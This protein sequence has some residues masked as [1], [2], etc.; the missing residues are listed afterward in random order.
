MAAR[1]VE[2]PE[3]IIVEENLDPAATRAF[4][5]NAFGDGPILP[6]RHRDRQDH[7]ASTAFELGQSGII[8]S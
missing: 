5:E 6:H 4:V 2:K 8:R 7:A 3:R 1:R